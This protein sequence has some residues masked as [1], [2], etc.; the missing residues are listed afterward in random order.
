[1]NLNEL[2]ECIPL[3]SQRAYLFSGGIAPLAQPVKAAMKSW[4]DRWEDDPL[5]HRDDYYSAWEELRTAFGLIVGAAPGDVAITENTS[6]ATN[7]AIRLLDLPSGSNVL[8]DGTTYPT[9]AWAFLA[10]RDVEVRKVEYAGASASID[11]F[12]R[13]TDSQT[14]CLAVSHVS[15]IDGY[16]H[17]LGALADFARCSGSRL[18]VDAAQ[19]TGVCP[20]NIEQDGVD[21]IVSTAMKWLLGPPGV[22]FLA[23]TPEL[24]ANG[25]DGDV[26]YVGARVGDT[27]DLTA[28]PELPRGARRAE[29]GLVALP[30][31]P[32]ATAGLNLILACG[33]PAIAEKVASL[34]E[35]VHHGLTQRGFDV[36][37]PQDPLR[38][39]GVIASHVI[40]AE[41]LATWLRSRGVDVWGY[42]SGRLRVDPHGFNDFQDIEMLFEG[43]DA[44]RK[45]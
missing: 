15:A 32:A 11:D 40:D 29:V 30:L 34:A 18:V 17:D 45:K 26:G 10:R 2:R 42:S 27:I 23:A 20:I 6:R 31:L 14:R 24:T 7:L 8:I 41:A 36:L 37:T 39:A 1:M 12:R 22:G 4:V 35:R 28:L 44:W 3:L 5:S 16:R 19:S 33:V 43:I 25:A 21:V 13:L 38:R 9:M